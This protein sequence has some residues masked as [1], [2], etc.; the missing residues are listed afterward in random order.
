M[1]FEFEDAGAIGSDLNLTLNLP[2]AVPSNVW[3]A[4][5][6]LDGVLHRGFTEV[7]RVLPMLVFPFDGALGVEL[8]PCRVTRADCD[9]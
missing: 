7:A 3:L 9:C 2:A 5:C 8:D 4:S 6:W 1:R